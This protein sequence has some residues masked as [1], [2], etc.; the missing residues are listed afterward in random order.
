MMMSFSVSLTKYWRSRL[1][2]KL[3]FSAMVAKLTAGEGSK[4]S[5][6]TSFFM[7]ETGALATVL[8]SGSKF[9]SGSFEYRLSWSQ[10]ARGPQFPSSVVF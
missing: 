1:S 2:T 8:T 5:E 6:S 9:G 7:K 3:P 10:R 4:K